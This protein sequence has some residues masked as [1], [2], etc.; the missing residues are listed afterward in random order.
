MEESIVKPQFSALKAEEMGDGSKEYRKIPIPPHRMTPLK[1]NWMKIYAPLVEHMKLQIRMNVKA[2]SVEIK[3]SKETEDAS[4]IQKAADF[5]RAFAMGFE[6]SVR[7]KNVS[8]FRMQSL[9]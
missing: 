5:V 6:V 9:C 4:Y 2:K 3:T 8:D 1:E 7:P